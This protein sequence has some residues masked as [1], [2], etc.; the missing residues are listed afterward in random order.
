MAELIALVSGISILV[1]LFSDIDSAED[2]EPSRGLI[3]FTIKTVY[4][5]FTNTK[6][7]LMKLSFL[8]LALVTFVIS[9]IAVL[10]QF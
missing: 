8:I 3:K 4:G 2:L 1:L 5:L 9:G 7:T 10:S 6:Q